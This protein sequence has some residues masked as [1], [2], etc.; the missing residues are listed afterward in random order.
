MQQKNDL[1]HGVMFVLAD[2]IEN[3]N[4][5]KSGRIERTSAY[6]KILINGMLERR[7]YPYELNKID[8]EQL[9]SSACLYDV[10]KLSIP[11]II[12]NKPGRLTKEEFNI[13]KTHSIKGEHII[14]RIASKTN[15]NK[16]FL[17]N[18]KLLAG[19]HHELWNGLGYPRGLE[20]TNIPIQGRIM[21]IIDV[22]SALVS[23]RPYK[24]PFSA[25]EGLKIIMDGAGEQFDPLIVEAFLEEKE[26]IINV[27]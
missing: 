10:G 22:F 7:V 19:N 2:M 5:Q 20:K 18:A 1:L 9:I 3:R 6:L 27:V 21:A 11:D 12:I 17:Q 26:Q 13:I 14:D 24:K 25:D 15:D 4:E 8:I 23:E 16:E